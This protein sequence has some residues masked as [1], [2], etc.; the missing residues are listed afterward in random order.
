[1]VTLKRAYEPR[2]GPT[3]LA[4]SASDTEHNA[5]VA[6]RDHLVIELRRQ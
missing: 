5:A 3:T 6:L 2:K 1:M 4:Y